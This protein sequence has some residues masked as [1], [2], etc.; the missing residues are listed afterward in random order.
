MMFISNYTAL[1]ATKVK[2]DCRLSSI[3]SKTLPY[4]LLEKYVTDSLY[5]NAHS[6]FTNKILY[7]LPYL[8]HLIQ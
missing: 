2:D 7:G 4:T 6:Y 3:A 1:R 5:E 8:L